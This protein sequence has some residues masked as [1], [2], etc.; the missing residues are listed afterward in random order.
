MIKK[1]LIANRG[2][3]A[4]RVIRACK[5]LGLSTVAV[6]SQIDADAL[7]VKFADE[8][9][10]IGPPLAS[11]SYLNIPALICAAEVTGADAVHP[12]YGFLAENAEF[13]E[14]CERCGLR[15]IGPTAE[16]MQ[17]MGNKVWA[18]KTMSEVG[19]PV[20]PGSGVLETE[21]QAFQAAE[22]IGYPLIIKAVAGG[23]GRGMKI[24]E[25]SAELIR[26]WNTARKEAGAAFSNPSVYVERYV[27]LP[28][29]IE[30]QVIADSYG[31]VVHLGDRECSIQRRHQKL[32][33]EAPSVAL[34]ADQRQALGQLAAKA[35]KTVGYDSVGTLEFLMDTSDGRLYFME[36]NT[37]IQVEHTVTEMITGIDLVQEQ[38]LVASGE[39]LSFNQAQVQL[40][41]HSIECRINAENP[42]SYAPSPGKITALH[43][44]GGFGVR[45]D[46]AIYSG[47]NV[48]PHYDSL[49][50]K[51]VVHGAD[52]QAA[53]ARLSRVLDEFVVEGIQTNLKLYQ[54]IVK[55]DDFL[56]G[57][58]DTG[59]L[60]RLEICS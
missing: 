7:H 22:E 47:Y 35:T 37:R 58:L 2:E 55:S 36:M 23:G 57:R 48:P 44:P 4:L 20:L 21:E 28:R 17:R 41:G 33:E 32:I 52:R 8:S 30:I 25:T 31:N 13:A 12:G 1:V 26:L 10:C 38:I 27:A 11:A 40:S 39:A 24:V 5:E 56:K 16:L 15:F 46:S 9:I 14:M 51:L 34:N 6:H 3:I 43:L 53:I 29:H 18:R 50:A 19:V 54:R 60:E 42:D 59:F 49:I 45:I